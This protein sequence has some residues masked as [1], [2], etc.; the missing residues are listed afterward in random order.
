MPTRM[1]QRKLTITVQDLHTNHLA[2][3]PG[4]GGTT[5]DDVER[6]EWVVDKTVNPVTRDLCIYRR[7]EGNVT[8]WVKFTDTEV[9]SL[10]SGVPNWGGGVA[11]LDR[12][13]Y[14]AAGRTITVYKVPEA[15]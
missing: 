13:E 6:L 3:M 2:S 8:R 14:D 11:V 7:T 10:V 1:L 12:I 9:Y 4:W 15:V 5:H